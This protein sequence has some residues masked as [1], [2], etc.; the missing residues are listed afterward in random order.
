MF[1]ISFRQEY[2]DFL[3]RNKDRRIIKVVS[4]IRRCEENLPFLKYIAT[5]CWRT[6][7]RRGSLF[8]SIFEGS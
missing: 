1:R 4:G 8:S 6:A 5:I 7:W 3:I 2:L